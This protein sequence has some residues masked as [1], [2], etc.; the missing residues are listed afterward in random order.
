[1][2]PLSAHQQQAEAPI[3][4]PAWKCGCRA[5]THDAQFSSEELARFLDVYGRQVLSVHEDSAVGVSSQQQADPPWALDRID[6]TNLPLDSVYNYFNAGT[7]V[8]VYVVDTV[9][10]CGAISSGP[11]SSPCT[12]FVRLCGGVAGWDAAVCTGQHQAPVCTLCPP[13]S[14]PAQAAMTCGPAQLC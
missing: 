12:A 4:L 2:C 7:G 1:M 8:H 5:C 6:Q 11:S 13:R 3:I 10:S 9:S 14:M